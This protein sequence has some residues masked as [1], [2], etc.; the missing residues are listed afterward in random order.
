MIENPSSEHMQILRKKICRFTCRSVAPLFVLAVTLGVAE[1]KSNAATAPGPDAFGYT[2]ARTSAYS[3][4][5]ITNNA[6]RV[7]FGEDDAAVF[8]NIGFTFNFYGSNYTTVGINLNGMLTFGGLSTNYQNV[9]LTTAALQPNLPT[10]AVYW[11]DWETAI[12]DRGVFYRTEG[13]AGSREFIVQWEK[14]VSAETAESIDTV[15][16]QARLIEGN[17]SIV[18]SF[19]DVVIADEPIA[20]Y[21]R[22]GAQTVGIRDLDG[23]STGRN[24]QWSHN[25]IV[26]TNRQ[27]ILFTRPNNPPVAVNDTVLASEDL[28]A[29]I[30]V[31][32]NDWDPDGNALA[33]T[34]VTDGTNGLVTIITNKVRYTPVMDYRGEDHFRYTISDG[35]GGT[36]TG[37]VAVTVIDR[38]DPPAGFADSYRFNEDTTLLVAAPGILSNDT[39][40]ESS[41]LLAELFSP[42]SH[43]T[44]NLNA[45]GSFSY[46]PSANYFGPDSFVY[47]VGDGNLFSGPTT[48]SITVDPVSDPPAAESSAFLTVEDTDVA[49]NLV[50]SDPDGGSITFTVV[51]LPGNGTLIGTAPNLIYHPATNFHGADA[52]TFSVR[53]NTGNAAT[54]T[55]LVT[56]SSVNEFVPVAVNDFFQTE[57]NIALAITNELFLANDTD[58]DIYDT[59]SVSGVSAASSEGGT[60]TFTPDVITYNPPTNYVGADSFTYVISDGQGSSATGTVHVSVSLQ[61]QITGAVRTSSNSM[62]VTFEAATG[63]NYEL[64]ASSNLVQWTTI[65][66]ATE[67]TPG[68]FEVNDPGAAAAPM[69]FYRVAVIDENDAPLGAMDEYE[70]VA[71]DILAVAMPGV[72][73]NDTDADGDMLSVLLVTPPAHGDLLLEPDGSFSYVPVMNYTGPDGF[74]YRASDG[75]SVSE[76]TVVTITVRPE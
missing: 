49:L 70:L 59:L 19:P 31:L 68:I 57:R 45:D 47:R 13:T 73:D 55:V 69:R 42:P 40:Q 12:V 32:G 61:I 48:V 17:N 46:V 26:L 4:T 43:G 9:N 58:A 65:G 52:F 63:V 34:S 60:L 6:S 53:D 3:F 44:L 23:Q 67:V 66:P 7:L 74:V 2:V 18:M 29:I 1:F 21:S 76:D 30:D 38:N 16:F 50:G 5:N 62:M 56:V 35:Q 36:S 28:P 72:L 71:N 51:T 10:V 39:D 37:I 41:T 22:G 75:E 25:Q 14:L 64:Q 8:A 20:S 11:D 15:T 24:L 27:N 54:G 33:I